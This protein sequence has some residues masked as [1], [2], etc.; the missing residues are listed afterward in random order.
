MFQLKTHYV[1]LYITVW[2]TFWVQVNEQKV[3]LVSSNFNFLSYMSS[4][5]I[6]VTF[7]EFDFF[8]SFLSFLR[9]P[10]RIPMQNVYWHG[11]RYHISDADWWLLRYSRLFQG[12]LSCPLDCLFSP[13]LPAPLPAIPPTAES[14]V[15]ATDYPYPRGSRTFRPHAVCW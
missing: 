10:L 11:H 12:R 9:L 2:Y 3:T 15:P 5:Q 6:D 14:I 13:S 4:I 8:S 1:R 7:P